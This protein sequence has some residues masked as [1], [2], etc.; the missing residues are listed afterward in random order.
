MSDIRT[1]TGRRI[2]YDEAGTGPPLLLIPGQSGDRRGCLA[3]LAA[4]L[5]PGF[6]VV[7]MDNRDA[8]ESEPESGY[9]RLADLAG[10]VAALLD[11]LG[12]A[13][14]HVLGHSL[15]GKIALQCALDHPARLARLVLVST[16]ADGEPSHR[17][18]DQLPPPDAWW[19]DDP[20]ERMRRLLPAIVGPDYRARMGEAEA[21]AIAEPERGNRATW[22]GTMRQE[23][24]I[25]G[26]NLPA[27]LGDI[28]TP[29]LVIH[30]DED[31]LLASERGRALADGIPDARL[32]A[33][34]GIG[35]LPW[36]ERPEEVIGAIVDFLGEAGERADRGPG[37]QGRLA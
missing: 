34:P 19:T 29:T 8:G 36:V 25:A 32:L 9:Y 24:A 16:A 2:Y 11:A 28:R 15:G 17:A 27:R 22:A 14:A 33:L 5:A 26:H 13:R 7:A 20:V 37:H 31:G 3:W 21:A 18:G 10:D 12:I 6:R 30:G 23:A 4:A 1:T 35:H